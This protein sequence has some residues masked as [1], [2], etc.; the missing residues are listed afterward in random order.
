M[1]QVIKTKYLGPTNFRGSRVKAS[2][3][4][5]S[6]TL[7]WSHELSTELNHVRAIVELH[8]KLGWD[9]YN[10]LVFGWDK[11]SLIGVQVP[12]RRK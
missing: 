8:R 12:K 1:R 3:E 9:K 11:H 7:S 4:A 2:C 6:I 5:G 10:K